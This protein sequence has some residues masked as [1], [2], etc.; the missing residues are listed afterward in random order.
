MTNENTHIFELNITR[1]PKAVEPKM[2]LVARI[3]ART[4]NLA[5]KNTFGGLVKMFMDGFHI[6]R[7]QLTEDNMQVIQVEGTEQFCIDAKLGIEGIKDDKLKQFI[8]GNESFL[9]KIKRK[10]GDVK[11]TLQ[12]KG[13][14]SFQNTLASGG[15]I[16]SMSVYAKNE[17]KEKLIEQVGL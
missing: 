4:F 13:W 1:I 5:Q 6:K 9:A 8:D 11:D 15:I 10:S 16:V 7:D 17:P 14:F 12:E 2:S 3:G